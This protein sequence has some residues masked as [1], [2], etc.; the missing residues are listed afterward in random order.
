LKLPCFITGV[1]ITQFLAGWKIYV[2]RTMK[3]RPD[4]EVN[5]PLVYSVD[6]KV[7]FNIIL[8]EFKPYFFVS[9]SNLLYERTF[10]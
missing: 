2:L 6:I 3:I 7:H 10:S 4:P 9:I 5:V 8:K 1:Q